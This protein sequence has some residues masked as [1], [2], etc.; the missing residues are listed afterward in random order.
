MIAFECKLCGSRINRTD[1]IKEPCVFLDSKLH[2]HDNVD[3][4]F[5]KL[6]SC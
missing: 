1:T 5:S 2:F 6:S 4:I 3:Y